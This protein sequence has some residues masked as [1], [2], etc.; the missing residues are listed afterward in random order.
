MVNKDY[1]MYLFSKMKLPSNKL[2]YREYFLYCQ[3]LYNED[4]KPK[5]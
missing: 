4:P 2:L 3:N 5:T 1:K